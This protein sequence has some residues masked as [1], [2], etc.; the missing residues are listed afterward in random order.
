MRW[1]R[2]DHGQ[3]VSKK[4]ARRFERFF[5]ARPA[6]MHQRREAARAGRTDLALSRL[7]RGG[8]GQGRTAAPSSASPAARC[9]R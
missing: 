5:T 2:S 3:E 4:R 8:G 7:F 1:V 6:P 9:T